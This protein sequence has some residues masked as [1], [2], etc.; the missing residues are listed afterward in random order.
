MFTVPK[1]AKHKTSFGILA[2]QQG[3]HVR[4]KI[5]TEAHEDH[6]ELFSPSLSRDVAAISTA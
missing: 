5:R 4:M 1:R 2:T 6:E 3:T